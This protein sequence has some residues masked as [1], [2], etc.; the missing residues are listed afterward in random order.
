MSIDI[1]SAIRDPNLFRPF[2]ADED[3]G[4]PSWHSWFSALRMV[5]GIPVSESRR[6]FVLRVT[7][8][9]VAKLP[10]QGFD[11]ALFLTGRRCGKSRIASVIGAYEAALA[12]HERKLSRG[13]RG[14]V[15]VC[16][17]SKYQSR[18][19]KDY[20]RA[21]FDVP[22]LRAEVVRE[23]AEGFE[24]RNGSRIEILTGDW[25]TIRG[26]TLLAAIV[27]EAAFF[28]YGE[29]TK[30]K[31]DTELM[32]AIRPGLATVGGKLIAISSPYAR[33]GWCFDVHKRNFGNDAGKILV[34]NAP[35]RTLNP[36][37]PQSVVDEALAEDLQAA[38]S[39]YL[40]EFRDDISTFLPREVIER[41]VV[42]GRI[43]L[44]PS[45]DCRY[46]AFADLSGGRSDDASL[47]IAH[48]EGR[49]VVIDCLKR[50]RPPFNPHLVI[51][52]MA[53]DLRQYDC[54]R[55]TGDNYAAEF[56]KRAFETEGLHYVKCD[57]PKSQLYAE[58]LP[59]L[60]SGDI[61]L[62]DDPA[63][64]H[65][66]SSLE[67]RTRSGGRDII[68]HPPSGHDDLANAVAGVADVAAIK[69]MHVGAF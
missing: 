15:A 35:S 12:G 40:A 61:E 26:Y 43:Q 54:G 28:G 6:E 5:Y 31:S 1:I 30:V 32:R 49:T 24:L 68:D 65:Q 56:V 27:D 37:L 46:F 23:T 9:E 36:T 16:S 11:T 60:M 52:D 10:T 42:E 53:N 48:R 7:G 58:L 18:I 4:L 34:L 66:L 33:K 21:I 64:I 69:R 38:K 41:L 67:R 25:R 39:E 3:D 19:V 47:A 57:K 17:P 50:F 55:V 29:D 2:L 59:R 44:M 20:L 8:R 14:I 22:M 62:L 63:L 51:L 13:E 45:S